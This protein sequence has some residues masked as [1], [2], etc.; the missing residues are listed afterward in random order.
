MPK[1]YRIVLDS[2]RAVLRFVV[3]EHRDILWPLDGSAKIGR[4]PQSILGVEYMSLPLNQNLEAALTTEIGGLVLRAE[5][6]SSSIRFYRS[7]LGCEQI[8]LRYN[9][10]Y[11]CLLNPV[12]LDG[13]PEDCSWERLPPFLFQLR[14]S[15]SGDL[16]CFDDFVN[17]DFNFV[18]ICNECSMSGISFDLVRQ[19]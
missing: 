5:W 17:D 2:R 19:W 15:H 7:L 11:F 12:V 16:F 1:L 18:T 9:K 3:R 14:E 8:A 6:L 4:L 13:L 10:E